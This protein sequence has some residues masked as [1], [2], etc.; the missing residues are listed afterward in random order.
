MI[1]SYKRNVAMIDERI[2][3]VSSGPVL[4]VFIFGEEGRGAAIVLFFSRLT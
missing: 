2:S 3:P 1:S 4:F